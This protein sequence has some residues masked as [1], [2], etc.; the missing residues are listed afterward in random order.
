MEDEHSYTAFDGDR[1]LARGDVKATLLQVKA[2]LAQAPDA[3]VLIFDDATGKQVDFDLRGTDAE[4]LAR[5]ASHPLFKGLAPRNGPGR[6]KLG[7]VSREV[8]LLPRHWDWLEAQPQGISATLRRLV[9]EARK[10]QPDQQRARAAREAIGRLLS[11]LAGDHPGYEEASRALYAKDQ[12]G[13]E[14]RIASWPKD[15]REHLKARSREAA[16][17]E[18][19][20]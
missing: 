1:L 13:F 8:T 6:P 20:S 9:D 19:A 14:K 2:R 17:L 15:L 11:A 4:A 12:A 7:V 18:G 10:R 3:P 5:L 16:A